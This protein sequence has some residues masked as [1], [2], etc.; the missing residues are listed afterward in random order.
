MHWHMAWHTLCHMHWRSGS[1]S[2]LGCVSAHAAIWRI[3][4]GLPQRICRAQHQGT[5]HLPQ[6]T[7]LSLPW[8]VHGPW[9]KSSF[10]PRN[11]WTL[12]TRVSCFF[13]RY[14]CERQWDSVPGNF[15]CESSMNKAY[16]IW[17]KL[18][19]SK[20]LIDSLWHKMCSPA[21]LS[22]PQAGLCGRQ[23]TWKIQQNENALHTMWTYLLGCLGGCGLA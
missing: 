16:A 23:E 15:N 18:N 9:E 19:L 1:K 20:E 12:Y 11:W 8:T 13:T 7:S 4:T 22:C 6:L 17:E 14:V 3:D 2:C 10:H 5:C 21:K